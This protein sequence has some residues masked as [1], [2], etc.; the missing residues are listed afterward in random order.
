MKLTAEG[1]LFLQLMLQSAED[2]QIAQRMLI[3]SHAN[4]REEG[5]FFIA[6]LQYERAYRLAAHMKL[7]L[8]ENKE[9]A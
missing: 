2:D 1:Q 3:I 5:P 9:G 4:A 7:L 6:L 8:Y